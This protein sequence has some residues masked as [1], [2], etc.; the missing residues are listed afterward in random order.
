M[1][2]R[3]F[4]LNNDVV[5]T[6]TPP[7]LTL[8]SWLREKRQLTG[9]KEGCGEG[10]CGAC[11]VLLGELDNGEV[12]YRAV[13]SCLLPLGDV[14]GRHV[15]TVEGLNPHEGLGPIQQHLVDEGAP[16]CGFCFPGIVLSLT[17]YCLASPDL[18]VADGVTALDGNICRCTG[19]AA[20]LRAIVALSETYGPRLDATRPRLDQLM[21]WGMLPAS[22]SNAVERLQGLA[23]ATTQD[24]GTLL[25]GGTDLIVQ[26]PQALVDGPVSFISRRAEW[27]RIETEDG[28]LRIGGGVTIGDLAR[29][30]DAQTWI[31]N[32]RELT[33]VFAS[34]LVRNRA[35]VAG[36]LVNASPIGDLTVLL[37]ALDAELDLAVGS[38]TRRLP[39]RQFYRGYRDIALEERE[40]VCAVVVPPVVGGVNFEKVS[41]RRYLDIAS[42]NTAA[43]LR[44]I[45]GVFDLVELTMGGVAPVPLYLD[46]T[47]AALRG[48]PVTAATIH[49]AAD[50][51][52]SEI[53]PIDDVRGS[54]A[55]KRTLARRLLFAHILNLAPAAVRYEELV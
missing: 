41:Q 17:G 29:S 12:T 25:G 6:T 28:S 16:Q 37:L 50:V 14:A 44:A 24:A 18:S 35:T 32:L 10:E 48:Q 55:Y 40:I 39:L 2:A 13:P 1:T 11:A 23:V 46:A 33:D 3:L 26:R 4:L 27:R 15:V 34:T 42:V 36:N 31:P 21:E 22:F 49:A 7:G 52:D 5:S 38:K 47:S 45:N 51:L 19:Y 8:L 43:V 54:A 20:I 30:D 9:T 53:A